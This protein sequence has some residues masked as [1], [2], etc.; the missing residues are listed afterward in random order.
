MVGIMV[1]TIR[2]TTGI[3]LTTVGAGRGR[4]IGAGITHT[5]GVGAIHILIV[6]T[7]HRIIVRHIIALHITSSHHTQAREVLAIRDIIT[8]AQVWLLDATQELR[9]LLTGVVMYDLRNRRLVVAHNLHIGEAHRIE[10]HIRMAR[11]RIAVA[12]RAQ[13]QAQAQ[14]REAVTAEARHTLVVEVL[15]PRIRVAV[16]E[17]FAVD[18][19]NA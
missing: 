5:T 6:L 7:D 10:A 13:T 4:G 9:N 18:S 12:R 14:A 8:I 1:G 11:H 17:M 2:S 15:V 3:D 19:F 16:A